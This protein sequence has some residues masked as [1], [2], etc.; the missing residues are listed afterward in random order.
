MSLTNLHRNTVPEER[1]I[2]QIVE[3]HRNPDIQT[4]KALFQE[5]LNRFVASRAKAR[6]EGADPNTLMDN[7]T[8]VVYAI[9]TL[10]KNG[11]SPDV[12]RAAL[13]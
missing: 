2:E 1:T 5:A 12:I 3:N 7:E 11:Y 13:Q 8:I 6:E 4:C 9:E 10:R